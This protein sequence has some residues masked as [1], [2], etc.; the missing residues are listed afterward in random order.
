MRWLSAAHELSFVWDGKHGSGLVSS[1]ALAPVGTGGMRGQHFLQ[2]GHTGRPG[3]SSLVTLISGDSRGLTGDTW[4]THLWR[5][6]LMT[7]SGDT[8][9]TQGDPDTHLW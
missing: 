9:D 3:H 8:R 6:N 2:W 7:L 5:H 1:P 4:D